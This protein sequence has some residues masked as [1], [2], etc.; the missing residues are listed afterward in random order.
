MTGRK[1][2]PGGHGEEREPTLP[3]DEEAAWAQIVAGYGERPEVPGD[4]RWTDADDR[5]GDDGPGQGEDARDDRPGPGG[6]GGGTD[7]PD[8]RDG[9]EPE[10]T[11]PADRPVRS[12][13]VYPA[14]TGPRDWVAPDDPDDDHF[15]PPEPPPLPEADTTTKFGW[16]AALG[17]PLLLL[18]CVLFDVYMTWWILTLGVGGF[19]GGFAALL[20]RLREDDDDFEDPGGGAVV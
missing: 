19:L 2:E 1:E 3:A 8:A 15:V 4:A 13:T 11:G 7:G 6:H 5:N 12:F 14:G 18:G 17:G 16:L 10:K 9:G 20:T